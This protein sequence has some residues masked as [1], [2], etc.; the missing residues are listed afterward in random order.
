[1][2]QTNDTKNVRIR[3]RVDS[4]ANWVDN[5]TILA[6]REIGYVPDGRYKIGNGISEWK[7]LPYA[8]TAGGPGLNNTTD[9]SNNGFS[10]GANNIAGGKGFKINQ[11]EKND[12][13]G[14]SGIISLSTTK[15]AIQEL[16]N[17]WINNNKRLYCSM[18]ISSAYIHQSLITYVGPDT[19]HI[20][21]SPLPE[22]ISLNGKPNNPDEYSYHDLLII[23]GHPE[24]GDIEIGHNAAAFGYNTIA[25]NMGAFAEGK[26]TVAVGKYAHAEGVGTLAGYA[27]HAEGS[28]SIASG[29]AS[30]AEGQSSY[31]KAAYTHAEGF[32]TTAEGKY[33]HTEGKETVTKGEGTH[34]EGYSTLA[35]GSYAHAEGY[36]TSATGDAT[37]AEGWET[38]ANGKGAHT[39]GMNTKTI[40]DGA[41]AEGQEAQATAI[42]AHAEGYHTNAIGANS[43]AEGS[44]TFAYS[45]ATHAEGVNTQAHY[46]S[47]HA[48]GQNA[49][50]IGF[51]AHAEGQYTE[52]G[53]PETFFDAPGAHAEG[54]KTKAHAYYAHSEGY[55]TEATESAAHAEGWR[56]FAQGQGAHAEGIGTDYSLL[57]AD[58]GGAHAEGWGSVAIGDGTHA[59]GVFTTTLNY[60]QD[61]VEKSSDG[62]HAE[63]YQTIAT[64][65]ASHAEGWHTKAYGDGAHAEGEYCEAGNEDTVAEASHAEGYRTKALNYA[66][67]TEGE[68]TQ[69]TGRA[70]HAEGYGTEFNPVFAI[71]TGAHAEGYRTKAEGDGAHAEGVYT[72]TKDYNNESSDGAHAEGKYTLATGI[73]AH[74]EGYGYDEDNKNIASGKGAHSE[75]YTTKAFGIGAHAEGRNTQAIGDVSHAEGRGGYHSGSKVCGFTGAANSTSYVYTKKGIELDSAEGAEPWG[76]WVTEI[77]S[78]VSYTDNNNN[79]V[80]AT[81]VNI[82]YNENYQRIFELNRTLSSDEDLNAATVTITGLWGCAYGAHAHVENQDNMAHINA[83]AEGKMTRAI[84]NQSHSEGLKTIATA[85]EQHVQGRLNLID[86]ENKYAHIVGNGQEHDDNDPLLYTNTRSNAHTLDWDGN[87]WFA[88]DIYIGSTSGK[89]KDEGSQKLATEEYVNQQTNSLQIFNGYNSGLVPSGSE[90]NANLYLAG[91]GNWRNIA[92]LIVTKWEKTFRDSTWEE[93]IAVCENKIPTNWSIG[94]TKTMTLQENDGTTT[95]YEIVIIDTN[96]DIYA[97]E[98]QGIAPFTFQ[99]QDCYNTPCPD[100][101]YGNS[102]NKNP[103]WPNSLGEQQLDEI[104]TKMPETVSSKLKLIQKSTAAGIYN[105]DAYTTLQTMKA[106]ANVKIFNLSACEMGNTTFTSI[107]DGTIYLYYSINS[108]IKKANGEAVY[109]RLR[110]SKGTSPMYNIWITE[111]GAF[112]SGSGIGNTRQYLS[113]A[114]CF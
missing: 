16:Q 95:N 4:E 77:G 55:C 53:N 100:F 7:D 31:A 93:I 2:S 41:H 30:H 1:M 34:A 43:H 79:K 66:A 82:Y 5:H 84:G 72:A 15:E 89:N 57:I 60:N 46:T 18:I 32:A 24:L 58:G 9:I 64:R 65:I 42:A 108:K 102:N 70:S 103:I 111:K 38:N 51:G 17:T 6:E 8:V 54:Y 27:A 50:A 97:D 81:I 85:N 67:H 49:I 107:T 3:S 104:V 61:G 105:S 80:E 88:G 74:A 109:W 63:G 94:D 48:E 99:F 33:S 113:P 112:Y 56:T 73:G 68:Y 91:D 71:G 20:I 25:Q 86:T 52:V 10:S 98:S 78:I 45:D 90:G 59:E 40:G 101:S 14:Q 47:A 19:N 35:Q 87:A 44:Q 36:D 37:H 114:F 29:D 106:T 23:D 62:A 75:G 39:E 96:H 92:N 83:H 11:I 76:S 12:Q 13:T 110:S 69:A 21:I 26:D 22:D 28:Q